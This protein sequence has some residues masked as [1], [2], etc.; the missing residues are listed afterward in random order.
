M[1]TPA[2]PDDGPTSA[3]GEANSAQE[4]DG[5]GRQPV[6]AGKAEG[7]AMAVAARAAVGAN[8][9]ASWWMNTPDSVAIAVEKAE[10]ATMAVAWRPLGAPE[11]TTSGPG[12]TDGQTTVEDAPVLA[13]ASTRRLF[14][15]FATGYLGLAVAM[16]LSLFLTPITLHHLGNATY[17]LWVVIG[18]IG[19]YLGLLDAGVSTAT[20]T[21]VASAMA[22]RDDERVAN[23]LASARVFFL[24]TGVVTMGLIAALVPFLGTVFDVGHQSIAAARIALVL[25]GLVTAIGF[26]SSTPTSAIFGSGRNDRSVWFGLGLVVISQGGSIVVVILGGG[27]VGLLVVSVVGAVLGYA[28]AVRVSHVLGL[29]GRRQGRVSRSMLGE[30]MRSGRRNAVVGLGGTIAYSFDSVLVGLILPIRQVT[31]YDLGLS[32]ANFVRSASTAAT[33]LLLPAYAHSTALDDRERQFRLY[34][35]AVL[36]SMCITVPMVVALF[37]FGEPLLRLWLGTVPARTF[38]VLVVTNIVFVVQL[39]GHQ[40]FIF[41]TGAGKN[42][43]LAR[44]ALPAAL[45]N[46]GLSVAATYRFGP[47]GPALGSLPQVVLLD[48]L[49]LPVMSCRA[50]GVPTRRYLREGMLPIIAPLAGAVAAAVALRATLGDTSELLGPVEAVLVALVAWAV[51][52][53]VLLKTDPVF[54]NLFRRGRARLSARMAG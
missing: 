28:I 9:Q 50:L 40:S 43:I 36:A 41:L 39:P 49:V 27:L 25:S 26:V 35:R 8:W 19:G 5:P 54:E 15:N 6:E 12:P 13:N 11:H 2:I 10:D 14:V 37:A 31:P 53:P 45:G 16:I 23:I 32:T 46:L 21:L 29:P 17:G 33:N 38:E 20:S 22:V 30:I 47:V 18:T 48:F 44:M 3:T 52:V 7:A 34:S 1:P 51:L 42:K 4:A 24:I